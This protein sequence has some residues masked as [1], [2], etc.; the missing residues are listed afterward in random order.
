MGEVAG[1]LLACEASTSRINLSASSWVICPRRTMYWSRSR[2]LSRTSPVSP[3][4]APITSFMAA[5]ILLPASRLISCAFAAISATVSFTSAPRCPG[6]RFGGITVPVAP[7]VGGGGGG[8]AGA[9]RAADVVA[10]ATP[11]FSLSGIYGLRS[12]QRGGADGLSN[13][14]NRQDPLRGPNGAKYMIFRD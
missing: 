12:A 5:A 13:H 3:A 7:T 4:A 1:F 2:A 6:L 14:R 10:V 8:A 9:V 11:G